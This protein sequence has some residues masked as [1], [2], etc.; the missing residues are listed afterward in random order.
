MEIIENNQINRIIELKEIPNS[1]HN[2]NLSQEM[3]ERLSLGLSTGLVENIVFDD[4][5]VKDAKISASL[6]EDKKTVLIHY[7]YKEENIKIPSHIFGQK[8]NDEHLNL[9]FNNELI[10]P[11]K[12]KGT[13]FYVGIDKDL[14]KI[15]VKTERELGIPNSLAN[16]TLTDYDKYQ[17]AN[18]KALS[19]KV[20]QTNKGDYFT[21]QMK[22]SSDKKG[23]EV[24]NTKFISESQAIKLKKDLEPKIITDPAHLLYAPGL[25]LVEK[26][27]VDKDFNLKTDTVSLRTTE[28]T[29]TATLTVVDAHT[30]S[31]SPGAAELTK[32]PA[33]LNINKHGVSYDSSKTTDGFN[34]QTKKQAPLFIKE[35]F[36]GVPLTEKQKFKLA[37]GKSIDLVKKNIKMR[38]TFY[39]EKGYINVKYIK[40]AI[41]KSSSLEKSQEINI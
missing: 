39:Q 37:N 31:S 38:V 19:T 7:D 8:L 34:L 9:L 14:N 27:N 26:Y 24:F 20:F 18:D 5:T 28:K 33:H 11:F 10:G 21:A 1:I 36:M 17:L 30:V 22:I 13:N 40:S 35:K 16:Y 29:P 32:K 15:T 4:G 23:V 6:S 12:H 25:E 2:I 41:Q 3:K